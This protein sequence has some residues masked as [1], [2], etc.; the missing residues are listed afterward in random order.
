MLLYGTNSATLPG[1]ADTD[2][3][4]LLHKVAVVAA[5]GTVSDGRLALESTLIGGLKTASVWPLLDRLWLLAAE[6]SQSALIDFVARASATAVNSPTFTT[7]RGYA[8][9]G[10]SSYLNSNYTP[11][12]NAVALSQNS[13]HLALYT[14]DTAGTRGSCGMDGNP[15]LHLFAPF[16]NGAMFA[17]I[18]DGSGGAGL[19]TALGAGLFVGNRTAAA[20]T[21]YYVNGASIGTDAVDVSTGLSVLPLY[22]GALNTSGGPSNLTARRNGIF[23]V[24][25]SL[26]ASGIVAYSAAINAHMTSIG[27]NVY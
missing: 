7:D 26:G 3:D 19:G 16:G 6:N 15:A 12:T 5:G 10:T 21:L 9:N 22:V 24:G 8:G 4:A 27:A 14:T 13:A 2:P 20:N 17:R 1:S 18:N 23:G 25:G 11:S